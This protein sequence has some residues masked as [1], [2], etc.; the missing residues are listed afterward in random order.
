MIDRIKLY[1]HECR[2]ELRKVS[3]P[4]R[5]RVIRDT[6]VVIGISLFAAAFFAAVDYGLMRAFDISIR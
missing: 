5:E 6:A 1:V 2:E 3:W 4:S